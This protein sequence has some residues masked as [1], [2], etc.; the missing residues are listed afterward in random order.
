MGITSVRYYQ[1]RNICDCT[2]DLDAPDVFLV[3]ENGQG[4]S[5]ILESI[6]VLCYGS[7]FRTRR[8]K[9]LVRHGKDEASLSGSMRIENEQT[10]SI[11]VRLR[12]SGKEITV[13]D[14]PVG[15]R[16]DIIRNM[17][18]IVFCHDDIRFVSGSPEDRRWFFNQ[19]L[20]LYDDPFL[21]TWRRY[22]RILKSRNAALRGEQYE[23]LDAYD[24]QLAEAGKLLQERRTEAS[25]RFSEQ[26]A[27]LY[28]RI[29]G[30]ENPLT[31]E[32]R[33]SW[34]A[35]S[36]DVDS[37]VRQ[38]HERRETDKRQRTT[39]SGPHRDRF[40]F[41]MGEREFTETASTGQLRL[42]SLVLRVAQSRFF[43]RHS[44]RKPL[45]LLDDVMLELDPL[46]RARFFESLPEYDQAIFTFLPDEQFSSLRK[47][48]TLV[49]TVVD[50][51]VY[52][53]SGQDTAGTV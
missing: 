44:K 49:Y 43:G 20:S 3:G 28:H 34:R 40:L 5:N 16:R 38:L 24:P 26:F 30:F 11:R 42:V 51:A 7:S 52:G 21:D 8:E 37:I 35:D 15:D 31:V 2:I 17:P 33:P 32:Y 36:G 12:S 39:T 14:S 27:Q 6:Y 46:R 47:S 25:I 10:L 50:G 23:L 22:V 53:T 4:K 29:S 9:H 45:L 19:T 1:F 41:M 18:C 48:D 13:N